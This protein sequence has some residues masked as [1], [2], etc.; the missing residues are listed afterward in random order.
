MLGAA[1]IRRPQAD[2]VEAVIAEAPAGMAGGA[3]GRALNSA[4]PR[5]AACPIAASSPRTQRSKGERLLTIVRSKVAMASAMPGA[6][7]SS[8]P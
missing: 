7:T 4:K 2:V 8:R 5:F 3:I 6:V 1:D